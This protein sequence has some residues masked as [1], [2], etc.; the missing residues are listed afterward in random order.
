MYSTG[1][2]TMSTLLLL[3]I[4]YVNVTKYLKIK[5]KRNVTGPEEA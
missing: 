4:H 1:N 2:C 3:Y 5:H